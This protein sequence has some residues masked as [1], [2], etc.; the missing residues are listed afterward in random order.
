MP[1][2]PGALLILL[3]LHGRGRDLDEGVR[4]V[5]H[6]TER[7]EMVVDGDRPGTAGDGDQRLDRSLR[8]TLQGDLRA[9]VV[10]QLCDGVS[11]APQRRGGKRLDHAHD[12]GRAG[13][14]RPGED[15]GYLGGVA[16][17]FVEI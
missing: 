7:I 8:G 12:S 13:R 16:R 6:T 9:A 17:D 15:E 2:R 10:D 1:A 4:G 3:D 14:L 11:L 5:E